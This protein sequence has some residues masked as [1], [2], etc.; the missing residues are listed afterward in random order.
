MPMAGTRNRYSHGCQT[1]KDASDA[2]LRSK[3]PPTIMV[4]KPLSSRNMTM[5]TYATG[6]VK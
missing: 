2:S 3:K 1:K 4:K 6:E 5:K